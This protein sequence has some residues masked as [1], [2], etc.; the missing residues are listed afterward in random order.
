MAAATF[1]NDF[2]AQI[3]KGKG[4]A[5]VKVRVRIV[6]KYSD[7]LITLLVSV[8]RELFTSHSSRYMKVYSLEIPGTVEGMGTKN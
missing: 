7:F 2:G 6:N 8:P 3:N 1:C 5:Q 4:E